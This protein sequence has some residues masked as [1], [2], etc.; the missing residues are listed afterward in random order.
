MRKLQEEL[1]REKE[2]KERMEQEMHAREQKRR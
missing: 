2:N 1:K